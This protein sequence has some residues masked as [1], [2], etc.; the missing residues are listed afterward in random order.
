MQGINENV[1]INIPISLKFITKVPDNRV[2]LGYII[3]ETKM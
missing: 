2:E 3:T 1:C